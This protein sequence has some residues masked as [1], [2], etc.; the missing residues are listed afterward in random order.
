MSRPSI[1]EQFERFFEGGHYNPKTNTCRNVEIKC[2]GT[3]CIMFLCKRKYYQDIMH[4]NFEQCLRIAMRST[5]VKYGG[6]SLYYSNNQN[7]ASTSSYSNKL[8]H[9]STLHQR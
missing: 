3:P 2:D 6:G 7:I 8:L 9:L 5:V 1:R 4:M